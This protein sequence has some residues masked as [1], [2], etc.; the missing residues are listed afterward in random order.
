MEFL[1]S[2]FR[3]A[4][5]R[6]PE[7]VWAAPG[8]I[9]LIGE[10]TDYNDGFALP[11]ALPH[12]LT[13]AAARRED[14][15]VRLRSR[16]FPGDHGFDLAG[17]APGT[18]PEGA[19]YQAGS[20]WALLD[21]GHEIGGLD[22]FVDSTIPA[23][24]GLSTSAALCCATVLA[25]TGLYGDM[26]A[27][28]EVAR[29]AQRAENDFVGMPCG[30]M[31]QSAVMQSDEGRALFLDCRSL[32]TEQEPFDLAAHGMALLVVDT[33]APRRLVEGAYAE[34]RRTCEEAVGILGVR[35]LRDVTVEDLPRALDAL[36][37]EVTRARVR[38]IVT[39]N[40]R[41]LKTVELLRAGLPREVGPLFTASHVSLRDDFEV[42][43]PEV[44]TAVEAA[45]A[46]GALGARIT[47]GGF[48]GCVI[49]LVDTDRTDACAAAVGSAFAE[50][51]FG[52]PEVFTALP[53]RGAR[54]LR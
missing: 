43:V 21:E 32:A 2:G 26:P 35:A 53:S 39:E 51:G 6:E 25:A 46:A 45:L 1:T 37:D 36:P 49:A 27:P 16:R 28:A 5:G 34:R 7:G 17:L 20:L 3:E 18:V 10:H 30:I 48:G 33:K 24:S 38:H 44:D 31:D 22:L 11:M 14:G 8:R 12:S 23:G 40:D 13:I 4:F 47:G 52:A 42:S 29:L 15:H 50:H 19:A 9:N 41:V 54:R